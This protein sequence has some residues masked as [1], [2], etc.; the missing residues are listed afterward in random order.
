MNIA[1]GFV[2]DC[3]RASPR[4]RNSRRASVALTAVVL[5]S[6]ST[7]EKGDEMQRHL[8]LVAAQPLQPV[9]TNQ[10]PAKV[11]TLEVRRQARLQQISSTPLP[12]RAA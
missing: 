9:R 8:V 6:E 12:P 4:S 1:S 5:A 7:Q 10:R 3:Q 11:V 2:P